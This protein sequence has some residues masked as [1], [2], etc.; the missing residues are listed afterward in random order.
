MGRAPFWPIDA[1][2]GGDVTANFY[3]PLRTGRGSLR[4]CVTIAI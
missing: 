2:V 1:T 4:A 3:T